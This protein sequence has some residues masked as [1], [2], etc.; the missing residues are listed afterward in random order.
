M[1]TIHHINAYEVARKIIFDTMGA[2]NGDTIELFQFVNIN[3][4]GTTLQENFSKIAPVGTATRFTLDL[5]NII[6]LIYILHPCAFF[7]SFF[8]LFAFFVDFFLKNFSFFI[9]GHFPIGVYINCFKFVLLDTQGMVTGTPMKFPNEGQWASYN[10]NGQEFPILN[11]ENYLGRP[12]DHFWSAGFGSFLPDRIYHTCISTGER[13]VW[14]E[15]D[16]RKIN[17]A[18]YYICGKF[19]T[20]LLARNF[21]YF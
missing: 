6:L 7:V 10:K 2:S 21:L 8:L 16:Y 19:H 13:H 1:V 17:I 11:F 3:S 18:M 4:T 20:H 15:L 9:W 14:Y 12:Y 5:G